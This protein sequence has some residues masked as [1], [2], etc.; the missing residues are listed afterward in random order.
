MVQTTQ[1]F[2]S[3]T[4][5]IVNGAALSEEGGCE[6]LTI[7]DYLRDITARFAEREAVVLR[8]P[9]RVVRWTYTTL[10]EKS[11]ELARAL[12]ACGVGKDTRVGV[13]MT[14]SPEYLAAIFGIALAG[15]VSVTLSTFS[16]QPEL[17][18]LLKI[19]AVTT[20]LFER[21]VAGKDFASMLEALEPAITNTE[22]GQLRSTRFPFLRHSVMLDTSARPTP[23]GIGIERWQ[24]FLKHASEISPELVDAAAATAK[25]ADVGV[26]FFSSGSTGLPKGIIHS[27]RAVTLQ[28]SRWPRVFKVGSDVRIWTSNGF[29]WSG[30]FTLIIGL[31]LSSGGALI[32]Q[33]TFSPEESLDLIEA[34]RVTMTFASGHQYARMATATNWDKVN[35]SRLCYVDQ[36][37]VLA[38]H[39]TIKTD[40]RLGI[41]F[42]ATETLAIN[43]AFPPSTPA[44]VTEG[45]GLPLPGNTLKIVDPM[46][47]AI[48][49]R[50]ERGELAIKG[51]TLMLGYLGKTPEECFDDEG[52]YRTGDGGYVD[53]QGWLFW[54]GRLTDIIK[55]G[56]ANVSPVEID[57]AIRLCPG[58]KV[59]QTVGLPHDTLGEIVV[60]CVVPHDGVTLDEGTVRDFLR[61]RL[62]SYK[63]PRRVVFF[64]EEEM[65]MTGSSKV[66]SAP[67]REMAAQRV[68]PTQSA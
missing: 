53:E 39:P 5:A 4:L 23:H 57:M 43:T 19:S 36:R 59:T 28:W 2:P 30:N 40:W 25:P 15:G 46:T 21:R 6:S 34:E 63:I 11:F 37:S 49:K 16:T 42:G 62:A 44:N 14:N 29:F 1:P 9:D 47:G 66:K 22:P 27:Q 20:L 58:V 3:S 41:A 52:F 10:W 13:M 64:R 56:G 26:L 17:E 65:P 12:M 50:G 31:G 51:A 55:T 45:Y 33:S 60:S 48:L 24:D 67:L 8:T 61:E 35:L 7:A 32:L 54:E 38:Q 18:H 68:G